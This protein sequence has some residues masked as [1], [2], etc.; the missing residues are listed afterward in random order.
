MLNELV[1]DV[2]GV[3]SADATLL[4]S[5]INPQTGAGRSVRV[6][7]QGAQADALPIVRVTLTDSQ[8]LEPEAIPH[9]YSTQPTAERVMLLVNVFSDFEPETRKIADRVKYLLRHK[10]VNVSGA[11]GF[12]WLDS[13]TFYTD[14]VSFPDRVLRV[15]AIR[16]RCTLEA[17]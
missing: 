17:Q 6:V 8:L 11:V 13:A 12:T 14:N 16:V 1:T 2:F 5:G 4:A 3:L 10:Q 15:C 9:D 7:G